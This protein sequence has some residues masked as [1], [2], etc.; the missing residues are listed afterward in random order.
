MNIPATFAAMPSHLSASACPVVAVIDQPDEADT[1][2][3]APSTALMGKP[4]AL[5]LWRAFRAELIDQRA[6]LKPRS[7]AALIC[8]RQLRI[9]TMAVM[10]LEASE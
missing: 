6:T 9:A 10:A 3:P 2:G 7:N 8:D 4:D 5:R 1:S